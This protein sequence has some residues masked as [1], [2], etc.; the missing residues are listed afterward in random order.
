MLSSNSDRPASLPS[1]WTAWIGD[2]QLVAGMGDKWRPFCRGRSS[3]STAPWFPRT[4]KEPREGTRWAVHSPQRQLEAFEREG[5]FLASKYVLQE[6]S[7][8]PR[9]ARHC[10]N[11]DA[12]FVDALHQ[13]LE[14]FFWDARRFRR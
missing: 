11:L 10:G 2:A 8:A 12:A 3:H 1:G 14:D 9:L 5:W 4:G 6:R 7:F 13:K